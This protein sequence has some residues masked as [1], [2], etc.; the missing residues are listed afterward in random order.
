M[1][2]AVIVYGGLGLMF[3]VVI[4]W[5]LRETHL[6]RKLAEHAESTKGQLLDVDIKTISQKGGAYG[7][8]IYTY[9]V[10]NDTYSIKQ[11]VDRDTARSFLQSRSKEVT[12]LFLPEKPSLARLEIAPSDYMKNQLLIAAVFLLSIDM[13]LALV[14]LCNLS[15]HLQ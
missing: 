5:G 12:V 9:Q 7:V 8:V 10:G 2:Q 11:A 1:A 13:V 15:S 6:T 3:L 14:I 4:I